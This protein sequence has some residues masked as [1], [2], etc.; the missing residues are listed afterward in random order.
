MV[1]KYQSL[2]Y[3]T[4]IVPTIKTRLLS[5]TKTHACVITDYNIIGDSLRIYEIEAAG[6]FD[7]A[8]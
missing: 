5:S 1:S 6:K 4:L 7:V 8:I 3:P 2:S